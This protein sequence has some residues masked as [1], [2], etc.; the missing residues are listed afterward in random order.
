MAVDVGIVDN[1]QIV[2]LIELADFLS[3]V[4]SICLDVTWNMY[5]ECHSIKRLFCKVE[6]RHL[7]K[8]CL[9]ADVC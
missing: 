8:F 7:D 1:W 6:Q 5:F 4:V 2:A 9:Q 3:S